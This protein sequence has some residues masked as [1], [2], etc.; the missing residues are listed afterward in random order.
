MEMKPAGKIP[1]TEK[2]WLAFKD[3]LAVLVTNNAMDTVEFSQDARMKDFVLNMVENEFVNDKSVKNIRRTLTN[4]NIRFVNLELNIG[5]QIKV[6][7]L[8]NEYQNHHLTNVYYLRKDGEE[9]KLDCVSVKSSPLI[10]P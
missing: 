3:K 6:F 2:E 5:D 8:I 4:T 7:P 10:V 1:F 9:C